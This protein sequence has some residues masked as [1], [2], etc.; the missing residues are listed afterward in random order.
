MRIG[1]LGATG[2]V[3]SAIRR[4]AEHDGHEVVV[5]SSPRLTSASR[6]PTALAE[7][8]QTALSE[9]PLHELDDCEAV[10]NAAGAA[11][12]GSELDDDLLGANAL[13]PALVTRA[14]ARVPGRRLVHISSAAVHGSASTLDEASPVEPTSPYGTSKL[15][16]E[17]AARL[18]AAQSVDLV[19][20][21]PT[22]VHG[23]GRALTRS[24]AG[25][26]RSRF[27]SV[28]RPG[29][30]PTPQVLV[31]NVASTAIF[32]ADATTS[33]PPETVLHPWE[34]VTTGALLQGLSGGA[35]PRKVPATTARALVGVA[36]RVGRVRPSV[37]AHARRLEMLWF[38]QSQTPGWLD[39]HGPVQARSWQDAYVELAEIGDGRQSSTVPRRTGILS[40]W[41]DPEPG[42]A[43]IPGVLAR[44]LVAR[45][46]DVKVLTGYPNYP[47]GH[48]YPGYDNRRVLT[49]TL[50]GVGVRRVPLYA[51]HDASALRRLL[52]YVSFAL[53]SLRGLRYLR[54]C[55][56]VWV[57]NS[58]PT[59][60]LP[61]A[62]LRLV[63][64][65]PLVLH[66]MDLWPDSFFASGFAP[67]GVPGRLAHGAASWV[68][69]LSYR[70]STEV[71][72]ISPSVGQVLEERGVP[73]AKL[74][75]APVWTDERVFVPRERPTST[76]FPVPDDHRVVLYAGAI[77]GAQALDVLVEA[78]A[79]LQDLPLTCLIAGDGT[80]RADLED[81][82]SAL[83]LRNVHLLGT[84]A[85]SDIGSL[86]ALGD[87]HVISL[88]S[89]PLGNVSFPSKLQA[90]MASARPILAIASGDLARV[91]ED[92]GAGFVTKPGDRAALAD[93]LREVAVTSHE[94]LRSMGDLARDY[95]ER[96]FA[97]GAGIDRVGRLLERASE[98]RPQ[99]WTSS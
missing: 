65:K 44:G 43:A 63:M 13:L 8:S 71:V 31:E 67:S 73:R 16:G 60:V 87:L 37:L 4:A 91:V 35:A 6:T 93:R 30:L 48:L 40:Q 92:S 22:S 17:T 36:K 79:D 94:S 49:E 56:V 32:L 50:E 77:G 38:G 55:E 1:L 14:M 75:Y 28:A 66:V 88:R 11:S 57:Y 41:Y 27:A 98:T 89:T 86:M 5:V 20:Y 9:H 83:G 61:M 80:A 23:A 34:G 45:G 15:L 19:V 3:G 54:D 12:P 7:E 69:Q 96:E 25:F 70:L 81:R 74:T 53:S 95:Y 18:C 78:M 52:N 85:K 24:L 47:S 21:R 46:H 42:P 82:V 64:R 76:G 90:T 10:I 59:V 39:R 26:S 33:R 97:S 51:S 2:F 62:F 58:P 29:N 84:V 99:K 68:C 72:Y